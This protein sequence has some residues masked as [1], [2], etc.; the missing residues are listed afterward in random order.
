MGTLSIIR[1]CINKLW[2]INKWWFP[3]LNL[4]DEEVNKAALPRCDIIEK[5]KIRKVSFPSAHTILQA[6]ELFKSIL[7]TDL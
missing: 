6:V 7:A 4:Q 5:N 2:Y 3:S 1:R